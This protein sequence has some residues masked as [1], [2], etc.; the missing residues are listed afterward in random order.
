MKVRSGQGELLQ[1]AL[2]QGDMNLG[3]QG[4]V[5]A[6]LVVLAQTTVSAQPGEGALHDPALG[7]DRE[8]LGRGVA[9]DNAQLPSTLRLHPGIQLGPL[10]AAVTPD[11]AQAGE[12]VLQTV[13]DLP[14]AVPVLDVGRR[15]DHLQRQPQRIHDQVSLAALDL[16]GGVISSQ[17]PGFRRF[18]GLAVDDARAGRGLPPLGSAEL[19][20][21][22]GTDAFPHTAAVPRPEAPIDQ[23]PAEQVVEQQPPGTAGPQHIQSHSQ[24]CGEVLRGSVRPVRSRAAR[25]ESVPTRRRIGRCHRI[26]VP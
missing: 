8:A 25:S 7:Q 15:H 26:G 14:D 18:H 24:F 12:V 16:L 1:H 21:Q 9:A 23:G 13:E 20:P 4:G 17:P 5:H 19:P 22:R 6:A 2:G 11:H 10:V 3:F